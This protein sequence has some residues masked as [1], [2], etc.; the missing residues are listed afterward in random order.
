MRPSLIS[1]TVDIGADE[2]D[3]VYNDAALTSIMS[4]SELHVVV[5]VLWL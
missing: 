2:Y 1:T 3:V 4:P 5:I